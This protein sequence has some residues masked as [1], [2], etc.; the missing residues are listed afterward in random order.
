MPKNGSI[1]KKTDAFSAVEA[2]RRFGV[3]L[4][5][6]G[7]E[8]ALSDQSIDRL[9]HKLS[10]NPK[11]SHASHVSSP[12]HAAAAELCADTTR[13]LEINALASLDALR[14]ALLA[15][16]N[17]PLRATAT[18][19]VFGHGDSHASLMLVGEAPGVEEDQ[20]G[21]PF[22]GQSGQLLTRILQSI[23]LMRDNVYITNVVP[24]RPPANRAPSTDEIAFYLPYLIRHVM[25]VSP[26]VLV[27]LGGSAIKAVLN[28]SK[29]VTQLRGKKIDCP[30]APSIVC[31][32]TYH[33][34]YLLRSPGQKAQVWRDFLRIQSVLCQGSAQILSES[35]THA[36]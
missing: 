9:K 2:S 15:Q 23:G 24:W 29:S 19:L 34:A 32:P 3:F 12:G 18:Q 14:Q 8:W 13:S 17:S 11:Y 10:L 5:D 30:V 21:L 31:V 25:L 36:A 35:E 6:L 7:V 28:E 27:L 20:Q 4:D 1:L 22:V 26:R 16:E 33:P